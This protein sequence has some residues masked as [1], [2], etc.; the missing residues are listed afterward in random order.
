[1]NFKEIITK[2]HLRRKIQNPDGATHM[3]FLEPGT[4]N[5][6]ERHI[7]TLKTLKQRLKGVPKHKKNILLQHDNARLHISRTTMMETTEKLDLTVL[8]HPPYSPGLAP[9]NFHSFPKTT[10]D[11]RVH[12]RD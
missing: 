4:T 8:P 5:N 1:L 2:V 7:A 11:I 3:E 12:L 9:C 10:E 6:A